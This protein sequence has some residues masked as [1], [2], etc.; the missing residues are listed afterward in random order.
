MEGFP[1]NYYVQ[2]Q[3]S[4][5]CHDFSCSLKEINFTA[6][7]VETATK[8]GELCQ[9]GVAV[10]RR[11]QI[12]DKRSFLIQPKNN[13]YDHENMCVHGITPRDTLDCPRLPEIWDEVYPLLDDDY[14][15][16]HNLSFDLTKIKDAIKQ[17]GLRKINFD[18]KRKIDTCR[19]HDRARLEDVC[20]HYGIE[21]ETKHNAVYDAEAAA[22]C[23][24]TYLEI[25]IECP[26]I[27]KTSKKHSIYNQKITARGQNLD[28][29]KNTE[30]PFYNKKVVITGTF[31][32]YPDRNELAKILQTL[33]ACIT[34]SISSKTNIVVAGEG[35]GW[36]KLQKVQDIIQGGGEIQLIRE[37]ELYDLMEQ[38]NLELRQNCD[39]TI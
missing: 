13:V 10:V 11:G 14:I 8:Q 33:G 15:L 3:S 9:I 35:A 23:Y 31:N 19:I 25:G 29:C 16:G 20:N 18:R 2:R 17:Y 27:A 12:V 39:K 32:R 5:Y 22:L 26:E 4:W 1:A 30:T 38:N 21:Q 36:A 24:L 37:C 7:D 6:I 28:L 34:S